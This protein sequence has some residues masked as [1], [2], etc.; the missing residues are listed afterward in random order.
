MFLSVSNDGIE[1]F[2]D[3][4]PIFVTLTVKHL[5]QERTISSQEITKK[6]QGIPLTAWDL[7]LFQGQDFFNNHL[8]RVPITSDQEGAI[9]MRDK[10]LL[11]VGAQDLDTS[12]YQVCDLDDVEIYREIGQVDVDAVFRPGI[13]TP[14]SPSTLDVSEVGSMVESTILIEEEQEKENSPPSTT[15]V[16][17]R[18]TQTTVLMRSCPFATN[19]ENVPDYVYRKLIE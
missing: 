6:S 16:S 15:P 17:E 1:W 4:G 18:S 10:M 13:D 8:A 5:I 19:I 14:F 11:T 3:F 2:L 9:Q 7:L 12:G